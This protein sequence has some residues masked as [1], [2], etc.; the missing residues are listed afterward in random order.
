MNDAEL[1][2]AD[3]DMKIRAAMKLASEAFTGMPE[4]VG[5]VIVLGCGKLIKH[6]SNIRDGGLGLMRE[7]LE[8][9]GGE[10]NVH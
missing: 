1:E 9:Q 10:G 5:W 2:I 3:S 8:A 7:A 4:G 6:G